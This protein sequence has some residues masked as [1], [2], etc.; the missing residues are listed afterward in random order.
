[1]STQYK[2]S[3]D[4]YSK[5]ALIKAAYNFIDDFYIHMDSDNEYFIVNIE[6]REA[7]ACLDIQ[8]FKNEMLIQETRRVVNDRT[9]NIREIMYSRAMASTVIDEKQQENMDDGE[10]AEKI[11][12]DWFEENE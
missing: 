7:N 3:K 2:F 4:L 12:V 5:E 6:S 11:L 10:N 1:M 8:E 9:M